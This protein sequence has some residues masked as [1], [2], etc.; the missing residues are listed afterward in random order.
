M[1]T[2]KNEIHSITFWSIKIQVCVLFVKKGVIQ[3]HNKA[4]VCNMPSLWVRIGF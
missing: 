1:A 2:Q 3:K 4:S